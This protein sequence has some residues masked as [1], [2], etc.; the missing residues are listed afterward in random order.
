MIA[1]RPVI[2][3]LE[4]GSVSGG[5][6][7]IYESLN[8]LHERGWHV[9]IYSL[10][11][12]KPTWFPLNPSIPWLRFDNY[13]HLSRHLIQRKAAKTATW[14]KTAPVVAEASGPGEG[15]YF[16][17][18]IETFY[19][20]APALQ[21]EVMTTYDLPLVQFTDSPYAS[22][23]LTN[24]EFIGLGIDFNLYKIVDSKRQINSVLCLSRPQRL[25]G[26]ST[27]C[28]VYRKLYH[29]QK[30]TLYSFGTVG[31]QPPY[32]IP[33]PKGIPDEELVR[34]YNRTGIFVSTSLHEGFGLT[35]LE[36]MA[37]GAVVVTTDADSNMIY[38]KNG[39]NCL[40]VPPGDA[41]AV[42]D[43]CLYLVDN[44]NVMV[45]LQMAAFETVKEWPWEPVI[46]KLEAIY[47]AA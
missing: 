21:E 24:C 19:Y 26:W 23:H 29:T 41:Q 20:T 18:D 8:R 46:D 36:A 44:P 17:Q 42:V 38:S 6:R 1:R 40:V 47:G 35:P 32:S 12:G 2:Y 31:V 28:E 3:V 15:F 14:W 39:E 11:R 7:I 25:K 34:F 9:E 27:L 5:V 30:F 45:N 22:E 37:C 10:D 33:L 16:V 4:S 13:E 43:A